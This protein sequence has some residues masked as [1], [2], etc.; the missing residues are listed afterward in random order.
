MSLTDHAF[1]AVPQICRAKFPTPEISSG[2]PTRFSPRVRS[3]N[4]IVIPSGNLSEVSSGN[5]LGFLLMCPQGVP[6]ENLP[7][8]PP[9]CS[10]GVTSGNIR[11]P[12]RV[13]NLV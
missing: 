13:Q 11:N 3:G 8:V 9:E 12:Q 1:A 2:I 10:P 5:P 4:V 7:E 6:S